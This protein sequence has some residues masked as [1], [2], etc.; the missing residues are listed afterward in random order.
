M[1]QPTCTEPPA[2]TP[3][4]AAAPGRGHTLWLLAALYG[5]AVFWGIRGI[6]A[7]EPSRLDLLV[8]LA[9]IIALGWWTIVDARRRQRPIP[10]LARP[11]FFLAGGFLVPLYVIWSRRWRGL[12]WMILHAALWFAVATLVMN[13]GGWIVF[14]DE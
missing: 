5:L 6:Y 12:G 10:L 7:S 14:G 1:S 4:P 11:W 8:Q 3:P 2:A 13:V 9:F